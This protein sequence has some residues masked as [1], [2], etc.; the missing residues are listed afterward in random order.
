MGYLQRL[1]TLLNV[2]ELPG[3][4]MGAV[5]LLL[6]PI[7]KSLYSSKSFSR[8]NRDNRAQVVVWDLF[9]GERV[10]NSNLLKQI[11]LIET[12]YYLLGGLINVILYTG[13]PFNPVLILKGL[14]N[15]RSIE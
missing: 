3:D 2:L 15:D 8:P 14:K 13:C 6:F 1:Y 4:I 9:S 11:S 7:L 10:V 12:I 5:I